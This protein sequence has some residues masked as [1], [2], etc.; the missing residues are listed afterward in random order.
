M[1]LQAEIPQ[2]ARLEDLQS[3]V[4]QGVGCVATKSVDVED[5]KDRAALLDC[6]NPKTR[7]G[8]HPAACRAAQLPAD[9]PTEL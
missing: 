3:T 4:L 9:R 6:E 2:L 1:L 5:G 8:D 7:E